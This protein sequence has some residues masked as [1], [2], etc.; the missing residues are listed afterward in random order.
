MIEVFSETHKPTNI[1]D[2]QAGDH[3]IVSEKWSGE[4][5]LVHP[6]SPP[7]K[8]KCTTVEWVL[9]AQNVV[10][11]GNYFVIFTTWFC[12]SLEYHDPR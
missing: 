7:Y 12:K 9:K 4:N 1:V 2:F 6:P 8:G 3:V 5:Q 11:S 10:C